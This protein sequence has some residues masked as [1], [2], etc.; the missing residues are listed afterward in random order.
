[1]L[2][3]E[4]LSKLRVIIGAPSEA[5]DYA[6]AQMTLRVSQK[7][8]FFL[9]G[10]VIGSQDRTL[11]AHFPNGHEDTNISNSPTK[12][13]F[14]RITTDQRHRE[15]HVELTLDTDKGTFDYPLSKSRIFCASA[16][17]S[18]GFVITSMPVPR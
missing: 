1:M 11:F 13:I 17:I 18:K 3:L 14:N 2:T 5:Y 16:A 12:L 6:P 15:K 9:T 10:A 4:P 8:L 7:P